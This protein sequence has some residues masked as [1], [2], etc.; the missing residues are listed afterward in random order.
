MARN[1][2]GSIHINGGRATSAL[3]MVDGMPSMDAG[4]NGVPDEP[5][6]DAI[7]EVKIMTSNY[8]GR[9]RAQCRRPDYGDH[10]IGF[11]GIPWLR[12][13]FLPA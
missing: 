10:Q 6:M 13:R 11:Q 1:A 9:V 5:N 7:A 4:N 8:P 12:L 2:L 3:M